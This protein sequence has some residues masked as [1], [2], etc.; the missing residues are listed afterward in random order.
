MLAGERNATGGWDYSL[1][2]EHLDVGADPGAE[3]A[4]ARGLVGILLYRRLRRCG[5]VLFANLLRS[6]SLDPVVQGID[7]AADR[8]AAGQF[9][10]RRGAGLLADLSQ[11]AIDAVGTVL[12]STGEDPTVHR[13]S[14]ILV[15]RD[16]DIPQLGTAGA[17]ADDA[18]Q[19]VAGDANEGG[20]GKCAGIFATAIDGGAD[21]AVGGVVGS[22]EVLRCPGHVAR[23]GVLGQR[24]QRLARALQRRETGL[25]LAVAGELHIGLADLRA[26]PLVGAILSLAE[27]VGFAGGD[28]GT[29]GV[30]RTGRVARQG[31]DV[32]H[33]LQSHGHDAPLRKD[34]DEYSTFYLKTMSLS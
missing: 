15:D 26:G 30:A 13:Q 10:G 1:E 23:A 9:I 6:Q 32:S 3:T 7:G 29:G 17:A 12:Q 31:V 19:V 2:R 24:G 28:G 5:N 34:I 4:V 8:P 16:A 25:D 22:D 21:R 14:A 33:V 27:R 20:I 18:T 11:G